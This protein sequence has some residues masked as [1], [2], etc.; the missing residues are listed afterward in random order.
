MYSV[1]FPFIHLRSIHIKSNIHVGFL[2]KDILYDILFEKTIKTNEFLM[3]SVHITCL[4]LVM[5]DTI[6]RHDH[7]VVDP[8]LSVGEPC[9]SDR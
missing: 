5:L 1:F 6:I 3:N 9:T 2:P 8:V 7:P 4:E